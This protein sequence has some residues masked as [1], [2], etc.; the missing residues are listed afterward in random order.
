MNIEFE[1]QFDIK[2]MKK[3]LA[4]SVNKLGLLCFTKIDKKNKEISYPFKTKN[5][6]Q[7]ILHAKEIGIINKN[8]ILNQI[9]NIKNMDDILNVYCLLD[10]RLNQEANIVLELKYIFMT[11]P[12]RFLNK[13]TTDI[14]NMEN[15]LILF[16]KLST[17]DERHFLEYNN[18]SDLFTYAEKNGNVA[19][20]AIFLNSAI[21][22]NIDITNIKV[23]LHN[24]SVDILKPYWEV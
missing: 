21:Y 24:H 13:F 3:Y 7:R 19:D 4:E 15:N 5:F 6:L 20:K 11:N 12:N 8:Y 18:K 22:K 9:A 16:T 10:R 1:N 14:H 23:I 2:E 17:S